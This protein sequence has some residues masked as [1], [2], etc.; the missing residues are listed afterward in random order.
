MFS[1]FLIV[2]V[3]FIYEVFWCMANTDIETSKALKEI[4]NI[5]MFNIVCAD[6]EYIDANTS[7]ITS[8]TRQ[9]TNP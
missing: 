6:Q 1:L 8:N 3:F 9:V 2:I 5:I 4:I 7:V